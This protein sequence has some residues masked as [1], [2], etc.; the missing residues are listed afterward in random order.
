MAGNLSVRRDRALAIGGFD[1]DFVPPVS[2]RFE[3]AFAK[4]LVAAGGRIRFEPAAEVRHLRATRGG[5]RIHGNHLASASPLHG[6]GDY[7]YALKHGRGLERLGYIARRPFREVRTRFH[8]RHPWFIPV[9][10]V[11]ELRALF[12]ALRLARGA[13]KTLKS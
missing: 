5:T 7:V 8:L 4:R 13:R 10:F 12:M 6:V 9:K 3:T 2:F 11:G 1:P